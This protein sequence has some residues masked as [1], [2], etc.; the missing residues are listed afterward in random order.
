MNMK[1]LTNIEFIERFEG[2]RKEILSMAEENNLVKENICVFENELIGTERSIELKL[3][4][5]YDD[6]I[7]EIHERFK[8]HLY[9]NLNWKDEEKK[10]EI[11]KVMD[12]FIR[13]ILE[14]KYNHYLS[15]ANNK[16]EELKE[17]MKFV[18]EKYYIGIPYD[19]LGI[20]ELVKVNKKS[21]TCLDTLDNKV[22]LTEEV[23]NKL[24]IP[25]DTL[26]VYA[27]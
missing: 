14:K 6:E 23:L 4:Y 20:L 5:C 13:Q 27:K 26:R 10:E 22:Y 17:I 7:M 3:I 25:N 19:L 12:Y 8:K 18:P 1:K 2:V 15:L 24:Y 9:I 11:L 21:I 16:Y